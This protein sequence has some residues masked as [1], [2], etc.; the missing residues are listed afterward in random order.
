[1][2]RFIQVLIFIATIVACNSDKKTTHLPKATGKPGDIILYMDS[3]QW[4]GTLGDEVRKVFQAEVVG[5]PQQEPMF[6][7]IW[8]QP[9]N[10]KT[11]LTQIRN[12]VYVFTLDQPTLGSKTLRKN[13]LPETLQKIKNDSSFYLSTKTDEFSKGQHVMYL[14]GNTQQNLIDHLKK[15]KQ[16]IIDYF[17]VVEKNRLKANLLKTGSTKG[18]TAFL[19]NEQQCEMHVPLGFR[20]AD[21]RDGFVW[22]REIDANMDRD[23]FISWKPYVSESQ[24]LTDSLVAWRNAIAKKYLFEDPANPISYLVTEENNAS[25]IAR[26]M[27]LN[28]HYSVELRGLWRTNNHTMGGPFLSYTLIDEPR[29]LLYYI[30]GFTYAPGKDKREIMR[31]LETVLSTFKTSD[32]L[33]SVAK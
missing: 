27:K 4:N 11:L 6:K 21:K 23:I 19:R 26:T 22:F 15:N 10:G 33:I 25:V 28:N 29:G 13:F 5:L 24:F 30:E 18:V 9:N 1:M 8:V 3:V 2:V 7:L 14:F 32:E 20:L 31:E 17:N 12:L 16:N